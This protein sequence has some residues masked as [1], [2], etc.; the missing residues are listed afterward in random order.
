MIYI[1]Q[2][3]DNP[4]KCN[5]Y[6]C[7]TVDNWNDYSYSYII[8]YVYAC[9]TGCHALRVCMS[10]RII[11]CICSAWVCNICSVA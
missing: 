3:L 10:V 6:Q 7:I 9:V 8:M 5:Q 2:G 11:L 1:N 4:I